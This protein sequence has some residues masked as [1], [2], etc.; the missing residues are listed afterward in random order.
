M[1]IRDRNCTALTDI[2]L[3]KNLET[4][5]D[6][7]F[8]SCTGLSAVT[9]PESVTFIDGYAFARCTGIKQITFEGDAP[10]I[11]AGAFSSVKA[12]VDYPKENA[13]WTENKKQNY[14]G[15]LTW[16]KT[17]PWEIKD[18]VLTINDDSVMNDYDSA[19]KTPWYA[20]RD[21]IT[22][23]DVYKRQTEDTQQSEETVLETE[24]GTDSAEE[25]I[26]ESIDE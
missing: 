11:K 7:A 13:T 4:I 23:I 2:Q 18:H 15:Q 21:G 3:P 20:D 24:Q 19:K 26:A 16:E 17:E 10:E 6:S 25:G 9:F 14:G 5:G 8:Y 1:C 12:D 22:S